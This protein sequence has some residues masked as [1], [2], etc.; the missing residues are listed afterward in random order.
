M[1]LL[2]SV[3]PTAVDV[4]R[5]ITA[6]EWNG[7]S[8]VGMYGSQWG[9]S[10]VNFILMYMI[11]AYLKIEERCQKTFKKW[12]CALGII[13]CT[14]MLVVWK[15]LNNYTDSL[16]GF[17]THSAWEYCNTFVIT[18]AV[19]M[20]VLFRN[21]NIG[22]NKIINNLSK[23]VFSVFLLHNTFIKTI[24]IDVAVNKTPIFLLFHIFGSAVVIYLICYVVHF[25]Y[26]KITTP[27]FSFLY[28][29]IRFEFID[30][31]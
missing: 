25:I 16:N 23:A 24:D 18:E 8:T 11:G 6:K 9:Y 15:L 13:L 26:S 4:F 19:L 29:K 21:I 5:E 1:V 31:N 12:H 10:I 20:F 27:L 30:L 17:E 28:K 14:L 3:W 7:L 22:V 2:F